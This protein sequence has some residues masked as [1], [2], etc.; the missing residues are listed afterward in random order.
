[1]G[2]SEFIPHCQYQF[3]IIPT[4]FNL[5]TYSSFSGSLSMPQVMEVWQQGQRILCG[6]QHQ[7]NHSPERVAEAIGDPRPGRI[8]AAARLHLPRPWM[9]ENQYH[10]EKFVKLILVLYILILVL[11]NLNLMLQSLPVWGARTPTTCCGSLWSPE[12]CRRDW[13]DPGARKDGR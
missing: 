6:D 11:Y 9:V 12:T 5:S 3:G 4:C 7:A 13:D 10:K 1:M 2:H 8:S